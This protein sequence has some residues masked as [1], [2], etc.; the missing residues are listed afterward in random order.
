MNNQQVI[1]SEKAWFAGFIDGEG[2]LGLRIHKYANGDRY[3]RVFYPTIRPEFHVVNAEKEMIDK[4]F[5]IAKKLDVNLYIRKSKGTGSRKDAYRVQ[6]KGIN[7]CYRLLKP[8]V[9]YL[10]ASKKKR[11]ELIVEFCKS[12]IEAKTYKNPFGSGRVKPYSKREL[13]I[14]ELT[15]PLMRRG[16]RTPETTRDVLRRN[17]VLVA[18]IKERNNGFLDAM[19]I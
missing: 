16:K 13:E 2:Y 7:R 18:K 15:Q 10:T 4:C 9:P 14:W 1:L 3:N 19:K 12:R 8:L 6:T 11:A 5:L 17:A